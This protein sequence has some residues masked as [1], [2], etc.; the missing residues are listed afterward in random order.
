M[1]PC[2]EAAPSVRTKGLLPAPLTR[3]NSAE[4]RRVT[5]VAPTVRATNDA[6]LG[7]AP[8]AKMPVTR[9]S[10]MADRANLAVM[11]PPRV[12]VSPFMV[13]GAVS[14]HEGIRRA[15]RRRL[16]SARETD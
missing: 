13:S 6:G 12:R 3:P 1:A 8:A 7:A 10:P 9:E 5:V 4:P 2:V 11:G 15:D 14:L 16:T